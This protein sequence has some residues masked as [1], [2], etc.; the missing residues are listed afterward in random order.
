MEKDW[1]MVYGSSDQAGVWIIRSALE[2]EGIR[3]VILD[4]TSSPY[5]HFVSG[6]VEIYV[7]TDDAEAALNL[8]YS[9][10]GGE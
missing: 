7:H 1:I 10:E 3:A 2:N 4:K 9:L 5:G 8:I 6:E